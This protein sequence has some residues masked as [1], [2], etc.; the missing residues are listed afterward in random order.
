MTLKTASRIITTLNWT[1]T[2]I[3]GLGTACL[4][5]GPLASAGMPLLAVCLF[6]VAWVG[7]S[8]CYAMT[9]GDDDRDE[10]D[11][12]DVTEDNDE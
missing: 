6:P 11:A 4:I 1:V 9:F 3:A 7:G 5:C 8:A 10:D 12:E 2:I